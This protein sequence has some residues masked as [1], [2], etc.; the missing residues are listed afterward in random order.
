MPTT[1]RGAASYF[2]ATLYIISNSALDHP[3]YMCQPWTIK[4]LWGRWELWDTFYR[5]LR[6]EFDILYGTPLE[7]RKSV[8]N[9]IGSFVVRLFGVFCIQKTFFVNSE[10][11]HTHLYAMVHSSKNIH[12]TS[13]SYYKMAVVLTLKLKHLIFLRPT[14]H[15]HYCKQIVN[16]ILNGSV[17]F[18]WI[19]N[20]GAEKSLFL[21][22][23]ATWSLL[24]A[25][26]LR[27]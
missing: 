12:G 18:Y 26:L 16:F 21:I 22:T 1:L 20:G 15:A 5:V 8:V 4:K 9:F 7:A 13:F 3:N 24:G 23:H 17:F 27:L 19:S 6:E 14:V 25:A 10:S 2:T 11:S